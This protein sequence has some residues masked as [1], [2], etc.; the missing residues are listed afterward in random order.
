MRFNVHVYVYRHEHEQR[1]CTNLWQ[2]PTMQSPFAFV[3]LFVCVVL[4][5]LVFVCF[6]YMCM[7]THMYFYNVRARTHGND[8]KPRGMC[9]FGLRVLVCMCFMYMCICPHMY[10]YVCA[11]THDNGQR[12]KA[13]HY[14]FSK[15]KSRVNVPYKIT[16][17]LTFK[18][19]HQVISPQHKEEEEEGEEMVLE[20]EKTERLRTPECRQ[21]PP[22]PRSST[23]THTSTR[24]RP[25]APLSHCSWCRVPC[26]KSPGG[27]GQR[28]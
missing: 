18:K 10:I 24:R 11:R 23:H 22:P 3:C 26:S 17:D 1:V 14:K 15:V 20:E 2:R 19:F 13:P 28:V 9:V 7:C 27:V 5:V 4:C 16:K 25:I 6:M 21:Q 12:C 8:T